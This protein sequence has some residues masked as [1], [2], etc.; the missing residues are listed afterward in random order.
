MIPSIAR[1]IKKI[2][3]LTLDDNCQV[4]IAKT[5]INTRRPT[6]KPIS[7]PLKA[8]VLLL[9]VKS[10]LA[11]NQI[12]QIKSKRPELAERINSIITVIIMNIAAFS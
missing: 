8:I 6:S 3:K 1:I 9:N 12:V 5:P 7:I 11:L 4:L 10:V 2:P